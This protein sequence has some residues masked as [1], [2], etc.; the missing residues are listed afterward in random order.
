LIIKGR[1]ASGYYL[2]LGRFPINEEAVYALSRAAGR[3]P[4]CFVIVPMVKDL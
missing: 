4:V 2:Q 1:L 3:Q